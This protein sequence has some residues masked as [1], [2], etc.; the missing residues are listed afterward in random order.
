M[1]YIC[2]NIIIIYLTDATIS[3]NQSAYAV[4]EDNIKLQVALNF[5]NVA[6]F[7]VNVQISSIEGG[8]A[9]GM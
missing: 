7:D 1:T 8:G 5:S 2:G 3:F 9:I 6:T 4:V